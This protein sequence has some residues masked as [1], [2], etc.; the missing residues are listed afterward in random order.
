M[1]NKNRA[2]EKA[3]KAQQNQSVAANK[4]GAQNEQNEGAQNEQPNAG[5]ADPELGNDLEDAAQGNLSM[6]VVDENTPQF[7]DREWLEAHS[8]L[9]YINETVASSKYDKEREPKI[10]DGLKVIS[11]IQIAGQS[12]NPL[13]LLL[14]SWWEVK[15]A[16]T[17]IKKMI[18]DEAAAKG[19][20]A[21][22]YMQVELAKEV[23]IIAE[24]QTGID[25][26]RYAKTYYKPRKPLSTKVVTKPLQIDGEIYDVPVAAFEEAKIKFKDANDGNASL[27]AYLI[28]LSVKQTVAIEAL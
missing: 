10:L 22:V 7:T 14:S 13:L 16:R 28:P 18:D 21:D 8:P 24:M 17:A 5:A 25:R 4:E 27:K 12:I 20:A 9:D 1:S 23:D 19:Y 11:T 6:H 3:A 2:A 26:I 15:P